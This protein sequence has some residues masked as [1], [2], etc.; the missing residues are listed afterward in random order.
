M[1]LLFSLVCIIIM[2][3]NIAKSILFVS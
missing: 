2:D 1:I 3:S